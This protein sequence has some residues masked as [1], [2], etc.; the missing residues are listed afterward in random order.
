[1]EERLDVRCLCC[2][3]VSL[4]TLL[5][6]HC[7]TEKYYRQ[8]EEAAAF[9]RERLGGT[10][11]TAVVLGSGLQLFSDVVKDKKVR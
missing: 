3:S 5:T 4:L 6:S 10:A 2:C 8:L 7:K 9:V 1:M 11:D